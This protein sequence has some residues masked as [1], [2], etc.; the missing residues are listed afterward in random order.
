MTNKKKIF[1]NSSIQEK[2]IISKK[3]LDYFR[4]I[5]GDK[6]PIHTNK[7]FA[8]KKGFSQPVVYGLLTS[9]FL[10]A[11]IG[12]KLPGPGALWT[13]CNFSFKNP[14]FL[15]DELTIEAKI[16]HISYS[17]SMIK[18]NFNISNQFR[19]LVLEGDSLVKIDLKQIS[20]LPKNNL[21]TKKK[22]KKKKE[23][24]PTIII[25][26]NSEIGTHLIKT[27]SKNKTMIATYRNKKNISN[28]IINQKKLIMK[29]LD[30]S[31]N[32]SI[33]KFCQKIKLKYQGISELVYLP[34]TSLSMK[35][36]KDT[37]Y[38]NFLKDFE[39][40]ALGFL[41][42]FQALEKE[43]IHG[44]AK[45]ILIS[46]ESV[47][48]M[49]A[50]NQSSYVASKS[51]LSSIG[52]SII[53]EYSSRGIKLNII[54]PGLIDTKFTKNIPEVSKEIYKSQNLSGELTKVEE[55]VNLIKFILN[56]KHINNNGITYYINRR[57]N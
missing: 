38:K 36:I 29:K 57:E 24:Y 33:K 35:N 27:F 37:S 45:I 43:L 20:N 51:A 10:S 52:K 16:V 23:N 18:I 41:K 14:V 50:K 32:Q 22:I 26:G 12:N 55:V 1:L 39:I 17:T 3:H 31:N 42:I 30:I 4:S 46:T 49:P 6:N 44:K 11:V 53:S 54:A 8:K 47:E 19:K 9:S 34:A 56:N 25:G 28:K 2:V 13:N 7:E 40:N 48:S 21:M 15:N 5:T